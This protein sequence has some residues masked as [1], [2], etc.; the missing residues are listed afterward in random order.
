[1][2]DEMMTPITYVFGIFLMFVVVVGIYAG[3]MDNNSQTYCNDAIEEFVDNAR[4]SG[5]ISA[6]A[7]LEMMR[8]INDSG[9]LYEVQ[10]AHRSKTS[11]P[12]IDEYGNQIDGKFVDSYNAYYKDEILG[13]IFPSGGGD[14]NDYSLKNGDYIKVSFYLKDATLGS[15]LLRF[16][17]TKSIKTISGSYG[18]YVGS[19]EES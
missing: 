9:N 5:Y 12:Y 1:M 13:Y 6:E 17:T 2:F 19:T 15:K 14:Y 16:I 10:I 11:M 8:K 18:G 4:A 7:Y 3:K